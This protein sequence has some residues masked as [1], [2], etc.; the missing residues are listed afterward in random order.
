MSLKIDNSI[1]RIWNIFRVI[2]L[3]KEMFDIIKWF[4]ASSVGETYTCAS[5]VAFILSYKRAAM[6][7][8][9]IQLLL[10]PH[11]SRYIYACRLH[12]EHGIKFMSDINNI[13]KHFSFSVYMHKFSY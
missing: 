2:T 7:E 8:R 5:P 12:I 6:L 1:F 13:I 4:K 9:E 3:P 11:C 10:S